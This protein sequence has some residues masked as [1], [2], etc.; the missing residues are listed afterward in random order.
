MAL[1]SNGGE[2]EPLAARPNHFSLTP[3]CTVRRKITQAFFRFGV[4]FCILAAIYIR[5]SEG[6]EMGPVPPD[7]QKICMWS[8]YVSADDVNW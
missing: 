1:T 2:E 6:A 4:L 7:A 5:W 8:W 3:K